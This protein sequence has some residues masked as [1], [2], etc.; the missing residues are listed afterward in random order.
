LLLGGAINIL[1]GLMWIP[2]L[3]AYGA[4][5]SSAAGFGAELLASIVVALSISGVYAANKA[6]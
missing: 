3:G 4:A 1:A 2:S 6:S 5:W